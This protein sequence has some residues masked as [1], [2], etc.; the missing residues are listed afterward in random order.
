MRT[1]T[2][3]CLLLVITA[4]VSL[5][6]QQQD[7]DKGFYAKSL[8]Y[9]SN[10]LAHWYAK[11]NGGLERITGVPF[12]QLSSCNGCHVRSCDTCHAG[13]ANGK[14]SYSVAKASSEAACEKCHGL[15]SLAFAREHP[16]DAAV[17]VHFAHGMKCMGCHSVRDVHGDGT[18]YASMQSV[19]AVDA[20]CDNCHKDAQCPSNAVHAGKLDC[21][22]CHSQNVASCYNCHFDTKLRDGKSVSLPLKNLLF[23]INHDGKVT[24]A[25][26]HTFIY[27][28]RTLIVFAPA[29][30]HW[31]VKQGRQCEEC[32]GTRTVQQMQAGALTLVTW[33]GKELS[34]PSA[35]VPVLD[36]YNWDFPFLN[37][38]NGHWAF[39]DH[40][41][42]PL[43]NYSGYSSPITAEQ[44]AKMAKR[45]TAKASQA[46]GL[47]PRR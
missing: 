13:N 47:S 34:G 37:Y 32:H 19:G 30:S 40:A 42:A 36:G 16:R 18:A 10:G 22:A 39:A 2:S 5:R 11:E 31:I 1:L 21:G 27:Q 23:L 4:A 38:E 9:T 28:N 29:F 44:L 17:D 12:S 35:I 41:A 6:G 24:T 45:Q 43:L 46:S 7:A 25:N 3:T 8:H 33:N 20:R 14:T 15:E 26:L